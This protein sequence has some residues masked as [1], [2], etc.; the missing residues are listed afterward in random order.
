VGY[1][2]A[3]MHFW[4]GSI[5]TVGLNAVDGLMDFAVPDG[6]AIAGIR[7]F[8][9]YVPECGTMQITACDSASNQLES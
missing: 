3:T 1:G 9:N 6:V 2:F 7:D 5:S 4:N 8:A